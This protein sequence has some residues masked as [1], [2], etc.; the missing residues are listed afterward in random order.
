MVG[1]FNH[2]QLAN[3]CD[4][5]NFIFGNRGKA[6]SQDIIGNLNHSLV[7]IRVTQFEVT[8]KV[9]EDR[10]ERAQTRLAFTYKDSNYD[11]PITDP[12]F[13]YRYQN[14]HTLLEG[15]NQLYL[16]LSLGIVWNNWY[17]KL[18]AGIIF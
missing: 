14:N 7:L 2:N 18:V 9:Y 13:L 15:I 11:F 5:R 4:N 12:V 17:Y 8:Q 10:P 1:N 3:C 16:C 6:V